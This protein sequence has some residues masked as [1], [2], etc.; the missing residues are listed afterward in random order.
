MCCR[1]SL[2]QPQPGT[3]FHSAAAQAKVNSREP[4]QCTPPPRPA[5]HPNPLLPSLSPPLSSVHC[6]PGCLVALQHSTSR[7][8]IAVI[9]LPTVVYSPNARCESPSAISA[10]VQHRTATRLRNAN[11]RQLLAEPTFDDRHSL[12][13]RNK[14]KN[15]GPT[16][17]AIPITVSTTMTTMPQSQ[18]ARRGRTPGKAMA[19]FFAEPSSSAFSS[20]R[21]SRQSLSSGNAP[22][23]RDSETFVT[24]GFAKRLGK[25]GG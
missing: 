4:P 24:G 7:M 1:I 20:L 23:P 22:T 2:R 6:P 11:R 5:G 18:W 9:S 3:R 12:A 25:C 13:K 19:Y 15:E 14:K 17:V 16:R 10:T 8:P 21:S